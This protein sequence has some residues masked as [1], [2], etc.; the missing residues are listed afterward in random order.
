M[1]DRSLER[2]LAADRFDGEFVSPRY[3][4]YCLS[5]VPST[6]AS[7]FGLETGRPVLPRS[8]R[9]SKIVAGGPRNVVLMV[10]DAFG[11]NSWLERVSDRGF[12]HSLTEGGLVFPI[13]TI[14]PSAT[15]P[16]LTTLSTGV[17]P[18][19]HGLPE[20]YVYMKELDMTIATLPF[21]PFGERQRETLAGKVSPRI[22]FSRKTL[23][24]MLERSGIDSLSLIPRPIADS[25]YT[26]LAMSGSRV[27]QYRSLAEFAVKIRKHLSGVRRRSLIYAYWDSFDSIGHTYGPKTDEW[28]AE[29]SSFS[30]VLGHELV[31]RVDR[32]TAGKTL[33]IVT[34]DHGQ[35]KVSP[36][37]AVYLNEYP[38]VVSSFKKSVHGR[39]ILPSWN[40][41]DV[42]LHVID[43]RVD[44][45]QSVLKRSLGKKAVVLKT[46]EAVRLGLFGINK[47]SKRFLDRA[48]DLLILPR[49]KNMV[50]YD[51]GGGRKLHHLGVHGGLSRD[52]MLIPF[53]VSRLSELKDVGFQ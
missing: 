37:N 11:Y 9:M 14:F 35:V 46:R 4:D 15:A 24:N 3:E 39:T 1:L 33:L 26:Q 21:S 8:R 17:T 29:I 19:E 50:W 22:L 49:K 40:P 36:S 52:E 20:W 10:L 18:Q 34:A 25:T 6:I 23:F 45:V 30:H 48:G 43:D 27:V 53:A 13:T 47:P 31:G 51:Y 28:E 5:S 2:T 44:E 38:E 41:R 16:A 7:I 42:A 12:F 32:E